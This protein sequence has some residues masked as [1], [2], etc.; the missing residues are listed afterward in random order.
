MKKK[1]LFYYPSNS[2]SI[3]LET[4]LIE[5][6]ERGYE[7]VILTTCKKGDFHYYLESIGFQTFTHEIKSKGAL[8]YMRQINFL[9]SFC[10]KQKINFIFSNLQHVNFISVLAQY[11]I[12]SKV[13]IFRHH[14]RFIET[15]DEQISLNK[16]EL[17]FD[18]IINKLAFKIIVPSSGVYNGMKKYE[19]VDMDK[20][21]II[22]YI[23]DFSKYQ[24]PN[25]DEVEKI[26]LLYPCKLRLLM[27]SRLIKLKR[28]HVVF[29]AV[30]DLIKMGYDI[31]LLVLDIG[32]EK[33]NL[34]TYISENNLQNY[35]VMLGYRTDFVNFM[36]A[37]DLLL[38]P[39][40]TDASNSAAK[41]MA[42]F[43]KTVAVSKG[44]GD[45][46]DY[47]KDNEN[48]YLIP[49]TDSSLHLKNIIIDAYNN[50]E[51]LDYMGKELKKEVLL[52]FSAYSS[53]KILNMYDQILK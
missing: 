29:A 5:L 49:L 30:N 18:K 31:K 38:Q 26:K 2:R 19:K 51:K 10:K 45:Y 3:A 37:A 44:V 42:F 53:N 14:F 8:Y 22:P 1:I 48:S 28:H 35:I 32:P 20:V 27:V 41:E 52:K 21:F 40:L 12:K 50:P 47:V 6:R 4:L 34:V 46:D 23:Y 11:F 36:A 15:T 9:I 43:E 13:F 33:E 39:S 25:T 17:F 24:L 7:I 16:N